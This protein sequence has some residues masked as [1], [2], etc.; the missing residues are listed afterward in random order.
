MLEV[1]D[2]AIR[3]V[4]KQYTEWKANQT[5][6]DSRGHSNICKII[7]KFTKK[8]LQTKNQF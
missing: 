1:L 8:A 5:V 4:I 2:D 6:F 3:K 7:S